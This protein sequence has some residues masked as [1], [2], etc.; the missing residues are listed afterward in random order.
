MIVTVVGACANQT[1]M[2]EG[3]SL[4]VES[5]VHGHALLIDAGPG[6][7][8]ALERAGRTASDINAL[9]L[10]HSHGDH[11]LGFT[12][13]V[14][15]RYYERLGAEAPQDLH[16]YA[17]QN[18]ADLALATLKGCYSETNFPFAVHVHYLEQVP[19]FSH[20]ALR[21]ET[22]LTMHTTPS[23]GCAIYAG[24]SKVA[25]SSDTLPVPAF[26]EMARGAAI[27]FH[28][29]MWTEEMRTLANRAM[30]STAQDAAT[31]ARES[32]AKQLVLL[33]ICPKF[34]GREGELLREARSS[35]SG[36]ISVPMDG[37]VYIT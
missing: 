35:F 11:I 24:D 36:S 20:G 13:F 1:A 29:G 2:R 34:I 17:L 6:V 27:L 31:V 16:V 14:W 15:Q 21:V 12:Y 19:S 28:E 5:D 4:L 26:I 22:C 7:V 32:A 9:L 30:H 18:A 10:T 25:Y 33:H 37:S 8:A 3:V 23:V